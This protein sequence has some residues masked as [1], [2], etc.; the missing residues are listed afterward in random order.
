MLENEAADEDFEACINSE[1]RIDPTVFVSKST[2]WHY[3]SASIHSYQES[4]LGKES[5][6]FRETKREGKNNIA[7]MP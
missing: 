5:M 6:L 7:A 3:H 4:K 1:N 2:W